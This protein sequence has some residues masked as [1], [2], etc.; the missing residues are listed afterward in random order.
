MEPLWFELIQG[1]IQFLILI[2]LYKPKI[3][4]L[5]WWFDQYKLP[6][7]LVFDSSNCWFLHSWCC[8][9]S[10][11]LLPWSK[12]LEK[13]SN[14]DLLIEIQFQNWKR[15]EKAIWASFDRKGRLWILMPADAS[16]NKQHSVR[17]FASFIPHSTQNQKK[18]KSDEQVFQDWLNLS[19]NRQDLAL[20]HVLQTGFSDALPSNWLPKQELDSTF[21]TNFK[22]G[23][24]KNL[25]KIAPGFF[26]I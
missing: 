11:A 6:R 25:R 20:Y 17:V 18:E 4:N 3:L 21:Q 16:G 19:I 13:H 5:A 1:C 9:E 8:I 15:K 10:A 22:N 26:T 2:M 12:Y 7:S 24:L 14:Q 23:S